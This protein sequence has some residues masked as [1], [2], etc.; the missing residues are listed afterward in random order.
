ML[1]MSF[2]IISIGTFDPDAI[3]VRSLPPKS[4]CSPPFT[5]WRFSISASTQMK[6]VGT[7]CNAVGLVIGK[8]LT[9]ATGSKTADG[10]TTDV[11][12]VHAARFPSTRRVG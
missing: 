10:Y 8:E 5:L 2:F 12:C 7:P 11:P 3:P 9:I 4:T 1:L 6:W